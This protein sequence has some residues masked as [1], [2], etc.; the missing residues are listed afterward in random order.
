[1]S[2]ADVDADFDIMLMPTEEKVKGWIW[3]VRVASCSPVPRMAMQGDTDN[4]SDLCI[5]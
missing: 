1:M 5:C 3:Q 2:D 4:F